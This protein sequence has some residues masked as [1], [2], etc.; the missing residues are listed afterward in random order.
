MTDPA[1]KAEADKITKTTKR[2]FDLKERL[3][4]RGLRKASITLF[5]DE[6]IGPKLGWAYTAEHKDLLGNVV[7]TERIREG[8]EGELDQ[9]R[10][11]LEADDKARTAS[12][13]AGG[14]TT[15]EA[16]RLRNADLAKITELEAERDTLL[17]QLTKTSL[18]VKMKAVP[19]VIQKDTRRKAKER[20]E[21]TS[22]N[23]PEDIA[24]EF[25]I[26]ITAFLMSE[27]FT[28]IY[29]AESGET[30]FEVTYEDAIDLFE[31]L[32]P[33][34]WERLDVQM[35]EIQFTDAISRSIE[36]QEDFS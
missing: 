24:E 32:P 21:I 19:P 26:A 4:G 35:G 8:V 7:R 34:Q 23:I 36:G 10:E 28:S 13:T 5:L 1:V 22:K 14:I 25:N 15:A 2:G 17:E 11:A 16:E 33:G 30:N 9:R 20:L 3:K 27:M 6:E 18:V 12:I 31:L 29:D